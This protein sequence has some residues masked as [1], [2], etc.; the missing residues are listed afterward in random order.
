MLVSYLK[1]GRHCVGARSNALLLLS[2]G[3]MKMILIGQ[4]HHIVCLL[5][6]SWPELINT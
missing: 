1:T 2:G 6:E 4:I 3:A 5:A